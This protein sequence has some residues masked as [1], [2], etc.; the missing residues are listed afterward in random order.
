MLNMVFQVYAGGFGTESK[1][2]SGKCSISSAGSELRRDKGGGGG[3]S[4]RMSGKTGEKRE[5]DENVAGV[6]RGMTGG[7]T[8][9]VTFSQAHPFFQFVLGFSG[10]GASPEFIRIAV[11]VASLSDCRQSPAQ[12]CESRTST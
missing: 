9:G 10:V 2:A 8:G 6:D 7:W 4:Q 3:R 5:V 12:R 1:T 11:H